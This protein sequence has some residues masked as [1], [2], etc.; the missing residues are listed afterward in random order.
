MRLYIPLLAA[1]LLILSSASVP[2]APVTGY[3]FTHKAKSMVRIT[4]CG[5]GL[6]GRIVWLR[7]ALNSRGRPV[8]DA[9]NRDKRYRGRRVLGL[10]TFSRLAPSGPG[11]WSGLMYN[12]DDGHTYKASLT[13]LSAGSIRVEGCRVGGGIC[14]GR[15]WTRAKR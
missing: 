15:R 5:A 4:R 11:R 14:G 13:L 8:R 6:C 10:R 1:G 7:K 9:R 3:W 12:P 2:A